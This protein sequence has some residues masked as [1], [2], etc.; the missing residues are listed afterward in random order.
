MGVDDDERAEVF[1]V[2][3]PGG[4]QA[5]AADSTKP[6]AEDVEG[7]MGGGF[8]WEGRSANNRLSNWERITYVFETESADG[9]AAVEDER[10]GRK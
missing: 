6:L 7:S 4:D 8:G 5:R 10:G 9:W 2:G 1:T 3:R